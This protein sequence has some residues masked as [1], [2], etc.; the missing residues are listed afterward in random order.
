V[1]TGAF[2]RPSFAIEFSECRG[3]ERAIFV[4]LNAVSPSVDAKGF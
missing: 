1:E 4:W 3:L 2:A